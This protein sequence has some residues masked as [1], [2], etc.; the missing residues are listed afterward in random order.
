MSQYPS[1]QQRRAQQ[2]ASA[3]LHATFGLLPMHRRGN[4]EKDFAKAQADQQALTRAFGPLLAGRNILGAL[5]ALEFALGRVLAGHAD[6]PGHL[7][8]GIALT[9]Q[10]IGHAAR[11]AYAQRKALEA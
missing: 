1:R 8:T 7:E 2:R 6:D 11:D 9:Q 5:I 3:K 4:R 10:H